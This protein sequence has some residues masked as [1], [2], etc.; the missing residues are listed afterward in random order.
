MAGLHW[1][2]LSVA[3]LHCLCLS[4]AGLHCLSVADTLSEDDEVSMDVFERQSMA[5]HEQT[6][7]WSM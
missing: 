6:S 2:C 3:D 5:H 1:L 4:V 7:Y